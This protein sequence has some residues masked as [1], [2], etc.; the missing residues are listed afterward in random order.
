MKK[1]L[2]TLALVTVVLGACGAEKDEVEDKELVSAGVEEEVEVDA[3]SELIEVTIPADFAY[4]IEEDPA[5]KDVF[6]DITVNDDGS[7]MYTIDEALHAE[8]MA[9]FKMIDL[10]VKKYK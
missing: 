7:V 2:M 3:E 9:A 4:G 8:F 10:E 6:E 5:I 1:W